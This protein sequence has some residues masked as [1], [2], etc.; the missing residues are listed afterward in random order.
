VK[1]LIDTRL[2]LDVSI[3]RTQLAE[4]GKLLSF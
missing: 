3:S 4:T 1:I 2:L